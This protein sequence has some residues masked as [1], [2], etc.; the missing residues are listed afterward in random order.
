MRVRVVQEELHSIEKRAQASGQTM[1]EFIRGKLLAYG[2][3]LAYGFQIG[4]LR[5]PP[6]GKPSGL[7]AC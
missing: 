6:L 3:S 5:T 1:S 4:T 7:V 2:R